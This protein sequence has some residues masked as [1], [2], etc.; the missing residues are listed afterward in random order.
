MYSTEGVVLKRVD[1]GEADS[2]FLIYTKDFGKIRAHAQGVKKQGAKLRGHLEPLSLSQIN[3]V[4]G[5][6]GERLTH[7][8]NVNLWPQIRG[9][10]NKLS[11]AFRVAEL[12]DIN[13]FNGDKDENLWDLLVGVFRE[14]E[15]RDFSG[16]ETAEFIRIFEADFLKT[17]GYGEEKDVAALNGTSSK[18]FVI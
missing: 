3:F 4:L 16:V 14:L 5:K 13:C 17:L 1:T 2:L 7:A 9:D 6:N 11:A 15:E 18:P 12:V 10:Y 8:Q